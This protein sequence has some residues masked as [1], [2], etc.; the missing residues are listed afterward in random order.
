MARFHLGH[1]SLAK[2]SVP[3]QG[4]SGATEEYEE[5][6]DDE[7]FMVMWTMASVARELGRGRIVDASRDEGR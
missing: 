7:V 6:Q 3:M 2:D 5:M 4:W 1:V